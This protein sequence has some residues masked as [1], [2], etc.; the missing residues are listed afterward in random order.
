[1]TQSHCHS[2]TERSERER[3][4][5]TTIIVILS[6]AKDL[7]LAFSGHARPNVGTKVLQQNWIE[8]REKTIV[9]SS[10]VTA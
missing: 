3:H 4:R 8:S 10:P 1:M 2:D 6:V 7:A 9:T 5:V